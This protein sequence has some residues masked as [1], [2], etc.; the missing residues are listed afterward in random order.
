MVEKKGANFHTQP[1]HL[2]KW[3]S[4]PQCA[5]SCFYGSLWMVVPCGWY[6]PEQLGAYWLIRNNHSG[7][8]SSP[9]LKVSASL[10]RTT[11]TKLL[12]Y[13]KGLMSGPWMFIRSDR[14]PH[15]SGAFKSRHM[16]ALERRSSAISWGLQSSSSQLPKMAQRPILLKNSY[17]PVRLLFFLLQST[18]SGWRTRSTCHAVKK[19]KR[20]AA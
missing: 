10:L 5:L 3:P 11:L 15:N 17:Y 16:A 19:S 9:M 2:A 12:A 6:F 20:K 18:F 4:Q 14:I 7:Q 13:G 1:H 8:S